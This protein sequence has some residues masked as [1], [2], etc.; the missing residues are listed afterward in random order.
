MLKFY[1][2]KSFFSF[3]F[4]PFIVLL[5]PTEFLAFTFNVTQYISCSP[6]CISPDHLSALCLTSYFL[7]SMHCILSSTSTVPLF[8]FAPDS[9]Y[10]SHKFPPSPDQNPLISSEIPKPASL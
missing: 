3:K 5:I 10:V 4:F 2:F 9:T 1:H 8:H 7:S 6:F